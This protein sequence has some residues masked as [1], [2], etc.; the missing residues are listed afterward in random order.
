MS[1]NIHGRGCVTFSQK[2]SLR[3]S[4]RPEAILQ[5]R[6]HFH[7]IAAPAYGV[8]AMTILSVELCYTLLFYGSP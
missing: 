8:L 7:V 3:R 1:F 2:M 5:A 4:E 6:F